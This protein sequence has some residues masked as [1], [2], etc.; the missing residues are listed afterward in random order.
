V[1]AYPRTAETHAAP[2]LPHL[3]PGMVVLDLGCG[4]GAITSGLARAV[5]PG[6][7]IGLDITVKPQ[8]EQPAD[9]LVFVTGDA[10]E[11]PFRDASVDAIHACGL[12][13]R[14]RDPMAV[15]REARRVARPGGVIA[16]SDID[17]DGELVYPSSPL[18]RRSSE[19]TRRLRRETSPYVG[20]RLRSLLIE[21]GFSRCV[22]TA[23]AVSYGDPVQVREFAEATAAYLEAPAFDRAIDAG[24]TTPDERAAIVQTW[25]AWGEEPGAFVAR[26]WCEAVG[27]ADDDAEATR[28]PDQRAR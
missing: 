7:T 8:V 6:L 18:L 19:I 25:R 15:L 2:L 24:W 5:E 3:R 10:Q 28:E 22:A 27:W 1:T 9:R 26:V 4:H 20:K 21:A 16:V 23:R 12:L 13:Q 17:W 11:L 14:L